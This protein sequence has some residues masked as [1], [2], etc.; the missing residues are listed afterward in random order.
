MT[1]K[2]ET[3][4]SMGLTIATIT[5]ILICFG[6]LGIVPYWIH[7]LTAAPQIGP[8]LPE[9]MVYISIF[10]FFVGLTQ[11][12]FFALQNVLTREDV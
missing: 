8:V 11:L 5:W 4:I 2:I 1:T 12:F 9:T 3:L 7:E 10:I 6:N